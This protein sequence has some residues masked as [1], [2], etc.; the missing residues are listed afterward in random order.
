MASTIAPSRAIQY[1]AEFVQQL[2]VTR[3]VIRLRILDDAAKLLHQAA[4]WRWTV[5]S[6]TPTQI[7]N[8]VDEITVTGFPADFQK[9][10]W[11]GLMTPTGVQDLVVVPNLP[12]DSNYPGQSKRIAHVEDDV[13]RLFPIPDRKS[14]V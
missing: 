12:D 5:G 7:T 13:V 11:A 14:V 10:L 1:A 9:L 4:P 2:P 3:D 8:N 6:L